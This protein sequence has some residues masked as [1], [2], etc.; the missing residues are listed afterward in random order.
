VYGFFYNGKGVAVR[1]RPDGSRDRS[2]GHRG[3]A[4]FP[5]DLDDV[6]SDGAGGALAV[7]YKRGH[8]GVSRVDPGGGL[9][10]RFG[11]VALPGAYNEY[12]LGI[13]RSGR[14][15]AVV[16]ARGESVCRYDCP[17]EP[18]LFRVLR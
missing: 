5:F 4:S 16:I 14:N 12:G 15:A 11:R 10:R 2:F 7:G 13:L 9:D 8:Y 18:K 17:S 3:V 6:V 1:L